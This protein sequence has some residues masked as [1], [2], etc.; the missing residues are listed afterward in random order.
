MRIAS[1]AKGPASACRRLCK[2]VFISS[3]C[4]CYSTVS[5]TASLAMNGSVP[6]DSPPSYSTEHSVLQVTKVELLLNYEGGVSHPLAI[7]SMDNFLL[8]LA[9]HPATLQV[10][11]AYPV[12]GVVR[13]DGTKVGSARSACC[14]SSWGS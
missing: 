11:S 2:A 1:P 14:W 8:E 5:G 12:A 7:G 13:W 4:I 10:R 9:V 3:G 6:A